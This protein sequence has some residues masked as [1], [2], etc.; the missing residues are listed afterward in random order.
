MAK[1]KILEVV[2]LMSNARGL[3]KEQV[4]Q[5]LEVALAMTTK[6]RHGGNIDVRVSIDRVSGEYET[7]RAWKVIRDEDFEPES[8][9][10]EIRITDA[11]ETNETQQVGDVIEERIE[12]V[13]LDRIAAQAVKQIILQKVKEASRKKLV[14]DYSGKVGTLITGVVKKVTRDYFLL[15][16]G[17]GV[18]AM[19]PRSDVLVNEALRMGDRIRAYLY[20]VHYEQRGAQLF[21]SRTRPE[22][23]IELF[24]IEVPE[25]G[26]EVIQIRG[27]ARDPGLRSKIAV[28]TNDGRIDP[29]GAC[30]G[31]RGSR[32]QAVSSELGGERVEVILWDDDPA[33]LVINAMAP[34]EVESSVN[35]EETHSID[36]M[37]AK[38]NLAQAIGRNGQNVKLASELTGWTLNVMSGEEAEQKA[39]TENATV[40]ELFIEQLGVDEEV[41]EVLIQ[42][43]FSSLEEV[44]YI[45]IEEMIKIPG[46]D[47]DIAEEL[48]SRA[49]DVLLTQ[50]LSVD[51]AAPLAST[52]AEDLLSMQGMNDELA[53]TLVSHG[54]VTMEDLAELSVDDL[55]DIVKLD[56]D[57]AAQLIMTAREPW[58]N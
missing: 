37:V 48:Q 35:Y 27:A 56:K 4:F 54:I 36:V 3:D 11:R 22:M 50:A 46:F 58:F 1:N 21:V 8:E 7:F 15:D 38:E 42:E 16:L 51:A 55:L 10:S 23:L 14:E 31:M 29:V 41:A 20:D 57:F 28:K 34:A 9:D 49:K 32:V 33:H 26:E 12:S 2:E 18:E 45:G 6:K 44:A 25:I 5:A 19:M 47:E 53:Q 43:G 24:K 30:V 39:E 52:P 40:L 13:A 17:D